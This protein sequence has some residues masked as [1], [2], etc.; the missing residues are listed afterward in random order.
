MASGISQCSTLKILVGSASGGTTDTLARDLARRTTA[1][2]VTVV[3][4]KPGAAGQLAASATVNGTSCD[5]YMANAAPLAINEYTK[6]APS[7]QATLAPI[8]QVARY[9]MLFTTGKSLAGKSFDE[10]VKL[11][12]TKP[13]TYATSGVGSIN[14]LA[15]ERLKE[16]TGLKAEH[17]P[18]KGS[19]E[20]ALAVAAGEVDIAFDGAASLVPLMDKGLKLLAATTGGTK[21]LPLNLGGKSVTVPALQ[22]KG[23]P[24]EAYAWVG[25]VTSKSKADPAIIKDVNV[26]LNGMLKDPAV[27]K[28]YQ[29]LGLELTPGTPEQLGAF[30]QKESVEWKTLA[31]KYGKGQ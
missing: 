10:V 30:M 5:V 11:S 15:M 24:F 6:N 13:L 14:H 28:K 25:L 8:G 20:A 17:I 26:A 16:Q 3:D 9:P 2:P 31:T 23:K 4:N 27:V 29:E 22:V 7:A 18:Y 12:Q 19:S 21:D 1:A